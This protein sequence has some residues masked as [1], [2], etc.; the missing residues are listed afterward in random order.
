MTLDQLRVFI[1]VAELQHLTKAAEALNLS[2]SAVSSSIKTLEET[3]GVQLFDRA[4]RGIQLTANGRAF[5]KEA[6]ETVLRASSAARFLSDLGGLRAGHVA[7]QASQ[8]IVNYWLPPR[9]MEFRS[10]YPKITLDVGMGNTTSV[11]EAVV[12]GQAELGF[13]EG[14]IEHPALVTK[15]VAVDELI[16]VASSAWLDN[17]DSL[18]RILRHPWVSREQGSGTRSVFEA[19]LR[20]LEVDPDDLNIVMTFPSNE[21]ILSAVR[22]GGC[23]ACLSQAV[24]EPF[25]ASGELKT[26]DVDLPLRR[27]TVL[28]HKER[29]LSAAAGEF[30]A[31]CQ[32]YDPKI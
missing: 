30:N 9:V 6:N 16:V 13:I 29:N 11:A 25:I 22:G 14:E 7:V 24:V 26:V 2:V 27:F 31:H 20:R 15:V 23:V 4:G 21:A 18:E 5:L 28:R 8:T 17:D 32:A 3:S 1:K 19:S 10:K 12:S